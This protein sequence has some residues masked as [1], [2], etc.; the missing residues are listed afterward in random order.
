MMRVNGEALV[1]VAPP[2]LVEHVNNQQEICKLTIAFNSV[3]LNSWAAITWPPTPLF[4][5]PE[6]Y[7]QVC[8]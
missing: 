3:V 7:V 2:F 8:L 1:C 5:T 6:E 4:S